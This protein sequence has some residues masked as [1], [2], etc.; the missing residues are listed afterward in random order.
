MGVYLDNNATTQPLP[1]V[2]ESVAESMRGL[3]NNPSSGYSAAGHVR[4]ELEEARERVAQFV[5]ASPESVVFTSGG[6]EANNSAIRIA[7]ESAKKGKTR[8]VT[9]AMEHASVLQML[10]EIEG[11][12]FEVIEIA[13]DSTGMIR[14]D[15]FLSAIDDNTALVSLQWVNNETGVVQPVE[16]VAKKCREWGCLFHTDAAQA[17]GKIPVSFQRIGAD[18]MT[19]TAHKI[20]GPLGAGALVSKIPSKKAPLLAGGTQE[21]GVR[22]G[23]ENTPAIIGF[24]EAARLRYERLDWVV[25][26]CKRLRDRFESRVLEKIPEVQLNCAGATRIVNTTSFYFPDVEGEALV[27]NLDVNG[28]ECSQTSACTHARPEPSHVLTAMGFSEEKAYSSVRFGFSELNTMEEAEFAADVVVEAF[29]RL[30]SIQKIL[31][32]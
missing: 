3:W 8:V 19:F 21:R 10:P 29:Q 11:L 23:T 27:N 13:A 15:E 5:D 18:L 16:E 14:T 1:E 17:V 31:V 22:P 25:E 6:T 7:L 24:G 9:S 26:H 12:G 20:H 2:I 28:V 30:Q 32:G 4:Q